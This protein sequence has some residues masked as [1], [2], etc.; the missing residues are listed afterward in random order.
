MATS[1]DP[2][3]V[4]D[5]TI[6][7]LGGID[8]AREVTDAEFGEKQ[9]RWNQD[10]AAIGR[11]LRSHLYV[12]H[13][14]TEYL[15]KANPRLGLVSKARLTFAQKLELIDPTDQRLIELLP[16]IKRLNTIRNRLAH[17]LSASVTSED[18][19]VFLRARSFKALRD[20]LA[21]PGTASQDPL[22]ILEQFA[23]YASE[24]LNNEFSS[25]GKA[26]GQALNDCDA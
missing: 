2:K 10:V 15:E 14:L 19:N 3:R 4:I 5:L 11:I 13:Y 16:G 21:R 6:E 9:R 26:F 20:E 25:L 23:R 7:I 1:P 22:D 8:K 24:A 12:E 17:R 18:A